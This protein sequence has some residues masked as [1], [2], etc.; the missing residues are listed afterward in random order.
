MM[1][2]VVAPPR[3]YFA[4]HARGWGAGVV[5]S[6]LD[7]RGRNDNARSVKSSIEEATGS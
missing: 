1:T 6:C 7:A 3:A 2:A 4:D 5:A